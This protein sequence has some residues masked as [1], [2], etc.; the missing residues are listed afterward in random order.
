[1]RIT[2]FLEKI[3]FYQITY[4]FLIINFLIAWLP[5]GG[6]GFLVVR[7]SWVVVFLAIL[8]F[9]S[10]W[11]VILAV[12]FVCI[13]GF[14]GILLHP[15]YFSFSVFLYGIRSFI[16]L[17]FVLYYIENSFL[18]NFK[19]PILVFFN[20]VVTFAIIEVVFFAIGL[21]DIFKYFYG[22][23][24][25]FNAKGVVSHIQ[26]GF[27]GDRLTSPFYSS[28]ILAT[29]LVGFLI[30]DRS[31]IRRVFSALISL[32]TLSKV[33]PLVVILW[34]FKK[35]LM[36]IVLPL[37]VFIF[38]GLDILNL[39]IDSIDNST[40]QYHLAS[41]R[42]RMLP[43]ETNSELHDLIFNFFPS[44]SMSIVGHL[45]LG[46]DA[47]EARE[48]LL[49]PLFFELGGVFGVFLLMYLIS[50]YVRFN[51]SQRVFFLIFIII[52]LLSSL[53][54]HPVA[55]IGALIMFHINYNTS[56]KIK[57]FSNNSH[58]K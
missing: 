15:D 38:F 6:I 32:L 37:F 36:T 27:F 9:R 51:S 48:S 50:F 20:F 16:F 35:R 12:C 46:L 11:D 49:L 3:L 30:Y 21:S 40:V 2:L 22:I 10:R 29:F 44:G 5:S 34:V 4:G 7:D 13:I 28:S 8:C 14:L 53:S 56:T 39:I 17:M 26:G 24:A 43:F 57:P 18:S 41:V 47:T 25:Y 58:G 55:F 23:D 19:R 54:N 42:N 52:Q 1:M 45:K 33:V 31:F